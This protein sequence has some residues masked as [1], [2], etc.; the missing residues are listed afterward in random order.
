MNGF[1]DWLV[2]LSWGSSWR[3]RLFRFIMVNW[4][5]NAYTDGWWIHLL[6]EG[7]TSECMDLIM[8]VWT[9]WYMIGLVDG[10]MDLFMIEWT[11]WC[12]YGFIHRWMD[13]LTDEWFI[14][15][16]RDHLMVKWIYWWMSGFIDEWMDL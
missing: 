12:I 2:L 16:R 14:D 9:F 8:Y 3:L 1:I 7:F 11:N 6:T 13:L 15:V 5:M 4:F 10:L